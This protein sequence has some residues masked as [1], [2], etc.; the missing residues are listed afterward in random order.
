MKFNDDEKMLA[1]AYGQVHEPFS[2][3]TEYR[4]N[5]RHKFGA[6]TR[7]GKAR[8]A[9]GQDTTNDINKVSD[10]FYQAF[11]DGEPIEGKVFKRWLQKQMSGTD[12]GGS[13]AMMNIPDT[14]E[15]KRG[16]WGMSKPMGIGIIHDV[17]GDA[18]SIKLRGAAP[19][20]PK[21][22][23]SW[24]PKGGG[25]ERENSTVLGNDDNTEE[26]ATAQNVATTNAADVGGAADQST[27]TPK[28]QPTPVGAEPKAQPTPVGAE[29]KAQP[30][31][32]GAG[33]VTDLGSEEPDHVEPIDDLVSGEQPDRADAQPGPPDVGQGPAALNPPQKPETT[34]SA[35]P[36]VGGPPSV[37]KGKVSPATRSKFGYP[38]DDK[39]T[40][41]AKKAAA[42]PQP[43]TDRN[44]KLY[45]GEL[46]P[47]TDEYKNKHGDLDP[48]N[49]QQHSRSPEDYTQQIIK[50]QHQIEDSP[51]RRG[52]AKLQK[53]LD[54]LFEA[55]NQL[56]RRNIISAKRNVLA[57]PG[58]MSDN[59]GNF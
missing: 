23:Y 52:N 12:L 6:P 41:D 29:P 43:Q 57:K 2:V 11:G 31:P 34:V 17:V 4:S 3:L 58:F 22:S 44:S 50:L 9:A 55:R 59:W 45:K 54:S 47:G 18:H 27:E 36:T 42:A 28:A 53:K 5:L 7:A 39:E 40:Q 19:A 32:V 15:T 8:R 33:P 14:V 20:A 24:L 25:E 26:D 51:D 30:T 56:I 37:G 49:L 48:A 16:G 35:E 1:E 21:K 46:T 38:E 13:P 10:R